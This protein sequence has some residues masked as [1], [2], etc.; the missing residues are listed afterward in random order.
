MPKYLITRIYKRTET[1]EVDAPDKREAAKMAEYLED[2]F[3]YNCDDILYDQI[4]EEM[5]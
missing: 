1:L 3:V 5:E 4:V 2:E